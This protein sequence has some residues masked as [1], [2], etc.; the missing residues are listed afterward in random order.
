[1]KYKFFWMLNAY[2]KNKRKA[3]IFKQMTIFTGKDKQKNRTHHDKMIKK[4][5]RKKEPEKEMLYLFYYE[6]YYLRQ[7]G[8]D[9]L[10]KQLYLFI[11]ESAL[12]QKLKDSSI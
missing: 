10:K 12:D 6:S 3:K 1:M 11:K 9:H 7:L 5:K 2:C 4:F 8:V